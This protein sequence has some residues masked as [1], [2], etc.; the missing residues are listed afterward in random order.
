M[1][2]LSLPF[3]SHLETPTSFVNL[4]VVYPDDTE[5]MNAVQI[6]ASVLLAGQIWFIGH[7]LSN[8]YLHPLAGYPGPTLGYCSTLY[9]LPSAIW[10]IRMPKIGKTY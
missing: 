10:V 2:K 9:E 3:R 1:F 4:S 6:V 7:G 5:I 8:L